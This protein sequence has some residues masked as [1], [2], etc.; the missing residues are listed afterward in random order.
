MAY[1]V[2]Q[3]RRGQ[4]VELRDSLDQAERIVLQLRRDN[5]PAFLKLLDHIEDSFE[6]LESGGL[7]LRPER[8]RW[9]SLQA[10]LR[11][12]A[13]RIVRVMDAAGGLSQLRERVSGSTGLWWHLDKV[14]E[15]ERRKFWKQVCMAVGIMAAVLVLIWVLLEYIIPVDENTV[16]ASEAIS[17][18]QQLAFE[19]RWDEA[20]VVVEDAQ[21]R[22]TRPDAELLIWEAVVRDRLGQVEVVDPILRE[23]KALIAPEH[24]VSF[25]WTL[26][27]AYSMA[28]DLGKSRQIADYMIHQWPGD[29]QGYFL[30]GSVEELEGNRG[31]A[32]ELFDKTFELAVD[33]NTQLAVIARVRMGT[34]LQQPGGLVV[35]DGGGSVD[36]NGSE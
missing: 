19:N 11:S 6:Q 33:S 8:S 4:A 2:K 9:L 32:I 30:L 26:G 13:K 35:L 20:L 7:D 12:D 17:T 21:E 5:A 27:S 34:L 31:L 18:I 1:S 24:E 23:A 28:S 36:G 29:A 15:E 10:K 22:L 3:E 16:V 14:V 25:W